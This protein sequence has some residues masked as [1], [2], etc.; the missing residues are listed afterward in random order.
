MFRNTPDDWDNGDFFVQYKRGS[1]YDEMF[2]Q[3][4]NDHS[5]PATEAIGSLLEKLQNAINDHDNDQH[6]GH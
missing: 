1:S 2:D 5:T 6:Q 4:V 3:M